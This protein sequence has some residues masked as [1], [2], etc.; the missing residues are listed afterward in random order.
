MVTYTLYPRVMPQPPLGR[1]H[2]RK[3]LDKSEWGAEPLRSTEDRPPAP[4]PKGRGSQ[5]RLLQATTCST[6][7]GHTPVGSVTPNEETRGDKETLS[8]VT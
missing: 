6:Q 3:L 1:V 2:R 8:L 7:I 5:E 4:A